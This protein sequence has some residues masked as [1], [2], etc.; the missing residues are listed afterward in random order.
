MISHHE[1]FADLFFDPEPSQRDAARRIYASAKDLPLV[2]PHGHVDPNLFVTEDGSF[3]SPAEL[4]IIPDHYVTRML[5]SQ[6]VPLEAL[7]V[8][9][10][11]GG[12][13]EQDGRKIWQLFADHWYLF[14]GTPSGVWL[15]QEL[16]DVFGV[17]QPL[18]QA[19][20]QEVY[21]HLEACLASPEFKPRRLFERF[22]IEVMCTTDPAWDRLEAHQAL[23][24]SGW[25]GKI[26][27]TFRP[28]GVVNL[29]TV[30]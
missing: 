18:T 7:G 11:D 9:R 26:R 28:D 10:L 30:G 20:A 13:V 14:R 17:Q 4:L 6:G 24:A 25:K 3:G 2:C 23:A 8:P 21:D 15:S 27:P 12:A 19:N 1:R 5:Y 29:D 16:R 22:N